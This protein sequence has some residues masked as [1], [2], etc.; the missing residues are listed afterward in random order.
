MALEPKQ[1]CEWPDVATWCL[2]QP[3]WQ[4]CWQSS[5]PSVVAPPWKRRRSIDGRLLHDF[6]LAEVKAPSESTAPWDYYKI[7]R[8][9]PAQEAAQ[10]LTQSKCALGSDSNAPCLGASPRLQ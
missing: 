7:R 2:W 10:P 3:E 1:T 9:I 8:I 4:T 5:G 6:F